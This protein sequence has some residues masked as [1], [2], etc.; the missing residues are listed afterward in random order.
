[1]REEKMRDADAGKMRMRDAV[2]RTADT[3]TV[4][5]LCNTS[6][7]HPTTFSED[8]LFVANKMFVST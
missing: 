8:S 1:M 5:F 2:T 4:T 7:N 6:Q 3:L